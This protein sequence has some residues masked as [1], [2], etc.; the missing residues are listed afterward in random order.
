VELDGEPVVNFETDKTR[1]LLVYL[2]VESSRP[3]QWR[4]P[5]RREHLAGL[6]WSDIPEKRALQNLRQTILYLRKALREDR[7]AIPCLIATRDEVLLNPAVDYWLDVKAFNG[8]LDEAYRHYRRR[9]GQGWLNIRPLQRGLA[10]F[11]DEFLEQFYLSGSSLF[12]EWASLQR[13]EHNRRTIEA[14]ALLADYHQRRSEFALARQAAARIVELAPWEE[15][16]Q[17]QMMRLLAMDKQWSAA[18]NQYI[19]LRRYL[20]EQLGVE[21]SQATTSL[22]DEIRITATHNTIIQS[23]FPLARHNLP[24]TP[25]PFVGREAVLDF[26]SERLSDPECRLLSLLGPG[27]IGKTRLALEAAHA[28]VGIAAD[29]VFFVPLGS[30][31]SRE[32]I[33]SAIADALGFVFTER[34]DPQTQILDYLRNKEILLVL[35]NFEHLLAAQGSTGL[36]SEILRQT[37]RIKL[38]VTTRERLYLQEECVCPLEHPLGNCRIL[39]RAEPFC[40]QSTTSSWKLQFRLHQPELRHPHLPATRWSTARCGAGRCSHLGVHLCRDSSADY[41]GLRRINGLRIQCSC[42]SPKS[43]RGI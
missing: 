11:Q 2:A 34:G 9:N 35:D 17:A 36:L 22:F 21:P 40:P 25:T 33:P 19:I 43:T 24:N 37:S 15:T 12:D 30:I 42:P 27:G 38:F 4:R 6:L 8:A 20:R 7:A 10:Q 3:S 13:E 28:Q 5:H 41:Q 31:S 18:Q 14:L 29:G 32:H 26:L 39:R 23:H 1:A 16:A